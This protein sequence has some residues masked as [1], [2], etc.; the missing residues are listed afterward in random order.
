MGDYQVPWEEKEKE[1]LL[2]RIKGAAG[3]MY[4]KYI[5]PTAEDVE[6]VLK[7][8][9]EAPIHLMDMSSDSYSDLQNAPAEELLEV[10]IANY[11][12]KGMPV[13]F[14]VRLGFD[15]AREGGWEHI[16]PAWLKQYRE[17]PEETMTFKSEYLKPEK[18]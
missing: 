8:M 5:P 1:R 15:L 9:N 4:E 11:K 3:K 13:E 2:K 7:R 10:A 18:Q 12:G 17:K 16:A 6:A 14:L